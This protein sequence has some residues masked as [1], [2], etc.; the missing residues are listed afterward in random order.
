M[1]DRPAADS[2][3]RLD[4]LGEFR[5]LLESLADGEPADPTEATLATADAS[6]AYA[7]NETLR[8]TGRIENLT[9]EDH[10]ET[11]GYGEPGRAVDLG[12]RVRR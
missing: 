12:V 2:P 7:L 6:V 10:Q 3:N 8:L 11:F 9:G 4:P 5:E 1:S